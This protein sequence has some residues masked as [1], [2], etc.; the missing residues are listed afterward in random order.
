MSLYISYGSNMNLEQMAHR[1][2]NSKI[3]G[4]GKVIGWQLVFNVHA[5]IIETK[6]E[7]D[8][9]PVVVWDIDDKDW[10]RLDMYEGYPRY[11]VRKT[12]SVVLDKT[13]ETVEAVVYVMADH[14]KGI[15]PPDR[16][17]FEGII[18]GCEENGID[19]D[20]LHDALSFSRKHETVYNQYNPKK[21]GA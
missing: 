9:V 8:S 2:P 15:C 17:Y 10:A 20:H 5:D 14:C 4:N 21:R 6:H 12:I 11:Y 16:W 1:C 3:V 18:V 7:E 19:T 13:G